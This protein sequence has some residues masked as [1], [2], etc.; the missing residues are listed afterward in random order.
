MNNLNKAFS[1]TLIFILQVLLIPIERTK[2]FKFN[3]YI[4]GWFSIAQFLFTAFITVV[5]VYT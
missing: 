2:W 3:K 4:D 5:V 1:A